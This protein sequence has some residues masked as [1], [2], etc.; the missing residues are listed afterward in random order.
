MNPS[1]TFCSALF[2]GILTALPALAQP[3]GGPYGPLPQ[4]YQP[5]TDA[6]HLYYVAPDGKAD[7]SGATLTEP[8]TLESAIAKAV[9]SDAVI[10][11]GGTYR[12]GNLQLN[13]GITLQPYADEK[14]VLKGT[15]VADQWIAQRNGLWRTAWPTLFPM[16]PQDWWRR[17]S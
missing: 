6:A 4:V 10:L 5:P 13:Q 16:K 8:T 7:A 3:S 11:R 14:P 17:G 2:A 15:Q 9:T 1:R 12:T